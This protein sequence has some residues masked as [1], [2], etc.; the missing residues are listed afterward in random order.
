MLI[1]GMAWQIFLYW[2]SIIAILITGIAVVYAKRRPVFVYFAGFSI[3]LS[4]WLSCQYFIDY[5]QQSLIWLQLGLISIELAAGLFILFAYSFP[6]GDAFP[7]KFLAP[8]FGALLLTGPFTF[9][10]QMAALDN[11]GQL[12]F[13]PLYIVQTISLVA[14]IIVG[15]FMLSL[16]FKTSDKRRHGQLRLLF[17]AFAPFLI[18][19]YLT[20]YIYADVQS[21]QF[22]RPL[23]VLAMVL[24]INYTII[25]RQLFDIRRFVLRSFVYLLSLGGISLVYIF[26]S[27]EITTRFSNQGNTSFWSVTLNVATIAVLILSYEPLKKYFNKITNKYFYR[28]AYSS[29]TLLDELNY[30]VISSA[31]VELLARN[32]LYVIKGH[33]KVEHGYIYINE[34]AYT[35]TNDGSPISDPQ[36]ANDPGLDKL[37][38]TYQGV[39]IVDELSDADRSKHRHFLKDAAVLCRFMIGVGQADQYRYGMLVMG[40]KKSGNPYSKQDKTVL[41]IVTNELEFAFQNV[42]RYEEIEKFNLTLNEKVDSATRQLRHANKK[43]VQMD[44]TKDEFISMASHQL[45]TPLTSVKG[46]LSMVLEGDAGEL[47]EM[48][49]KL[50]DQAY[51]SSQRMVFLI[52]DLLNV[53]RLKTGRFII[54]NTPTNLA[55]TIQGEVAQLVD[56][57]KSRGL[58]LTYKRPDNFP[59]LMLDETKTRQVIMNFI[60]NA[61][62]YTP[63]GGH[64]DVALT[65]TDKTIEFKVKDNGIGVPKADQ[66]G[67][68]GKFYR[69]GNAR[70]ARPDGTGLGLYMAKKVVIAQGGVINFKSEQGKGSVFGFTFAKDK[71]KLPETPKTPQAA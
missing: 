15:L 41:R 14:S 33:M 43:L 68:F 28:D 23:G 55:D 59:V 56:T 57:A 61:I 44:E 30:A 1:T 39:I 31:G 50:L 27:R 32:I 13:G 17:L 18:L 66:P 4:F 58:T 52:A 34:T 3:A 19:S 10:S 48:Q 46:Y 64:I 40:N 62:Y 67:L 9:S 53:S 47:N 12:V 36:A 24:I 70:K 26:F 16:H 54:E 22:L 63:Q 35:D 6:D 2:S 25:A 69:A 37:F 21:V 20:G 65:E 8:A 29:Q 42:L 5:S 60:D 38:K 7:K 51:I 11:A 71:L 49:R 45:R